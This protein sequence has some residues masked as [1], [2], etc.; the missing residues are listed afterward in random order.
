MRCNLNFFS[1]L[2]LSFEGLHFVAGFFGFGLSV[3][4]LLQVSDGFLLL[5]LFRYIASEGA[6]D[7]VELLEF[8]LSD[9]ALSVVQVVLFSA[10]LLDWFVVRGVASLFQS[11]S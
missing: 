6:V 2:D 10:I 7:L 8:V 1:F 4:Y 3:L 9:N 11:S 5:E